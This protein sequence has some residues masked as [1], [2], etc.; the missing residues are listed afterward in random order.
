MGKIIDKRKK[1]YRD[2][3]KVSKGGRVFSRDKKHTGI[4]MGDAAPYVG[5]AG[6]SSR[7]KVLWKDGRTTLCTV[8]GMKE[9]KKGWQ[10]L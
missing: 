3:M 5:E 8:K 1:L 2:L 6:Y 7:F 4:I 9:T 10:I